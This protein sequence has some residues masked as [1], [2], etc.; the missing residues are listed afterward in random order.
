MGFLDELDGDIQRALAKVGEASAA[1]EPSPGLTVPALLRVALKNE[2]EASEIAA[3]WMASEPDVEVKLALAR[4][5]GDEAK[6]YR[7]IQDRLAGLGVS[8]E[9]WGPLQDGYS[10]MFQ[11]LRGLE[12]TVPRVAAG[13]FAREALAQVRNEV[14]IGFCERS[15]DAQTARLYREVVQPD[16]AHHHRMGRTL[17][18]RLCS[19]DQDRAAA[20][21]AAS[22]TLAIAE[23]LQEI[24][25]LKKGIS[26]APGC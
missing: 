13:Q 3:L 11:F 25:R 23:E 17:L 6:H 2:L 24:A 9:G 10:P 26:R 18:E 22:R 4:Q 12:G 1:G 14:F 16:E 21:A 5:C 19:T 20:R 7:L 8:L 15:G